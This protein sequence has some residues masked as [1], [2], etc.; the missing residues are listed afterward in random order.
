[1]AGNIYERELRKILSGEKAYIEKITK[2]YP[3]EQ[4]ELYLKIV[5]RPFLVLRAA[6]SFGIDIVAIRDD[7]SFP[8]EV[9]SSHYNVFRFTMSNGKAQDQ[10]LNHIRDTGRAGLFP[11]YAYRIKNVH[12]DPWRLFVP[13]G[14]NVR[15]NMMLVY[16]LLP[17]IEITNSGNYLMR[18]DQGFPLHK[19]ID[20]LTKKYL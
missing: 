3:V 13:P 16:I 14:L 18:W 9:K 8:I 5:E 7:F 11:L 19:F 12:G 10:I 17:K 2:S 15:G 6:G 4:R 1:M 20:Y